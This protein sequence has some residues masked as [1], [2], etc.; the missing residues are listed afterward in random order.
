MRNLLIILSF[1]CSIQSIASSGWVVTLKS[2]KV[3]VYK[4]SEHPNVYVSVTDKVH[5]EARPIKIERKQ[6]DNKTVLKLIGV[7]KWDLKE[8]NWN[9]VDNTLNALGTFVDFKKDVN[10]FR[11]S[12]RYSSKRTTLFLMTS[13]KEEPTL[14]GDLLNK[15]VEEFLGDKI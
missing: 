1:V 4:N 7:T 5:T 8:F 11:E 13:V 15:F 2:G 3:K 12:H 9:D 6:F 14:K 10:Y